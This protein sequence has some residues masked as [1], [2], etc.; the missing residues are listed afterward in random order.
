[1]APQSQVFSDDFA[2]AFQKL[3]DGNGKANEIFQQAMQ[4]LRDSGHAYD[5]KTLHPD[6][7]MTHT[8]NRGGLMLSPYNCHSNAR[9]E[10]HNVGADCKQ[11][12]NAVAVELSEQNSAGHIQANERLIKRSKG[13]L[14]PLNGKERYA[15]LGAGHT[16]AWCKLAG[17]GGPTPEKPLQDEHGKIDVQKICRNAEFKAMIEE[18]WSWEIVKAAVDVRFP[19]FAVIAQEALNTQ[20]HV[21]RRW[22]YLGLRE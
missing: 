5:M 9:K 8:R 11:L 6:L 20:N 2:T 10:V 13:L 4:M 12:S 15:T 7:F 17:V 1:M 18:G 3:L 19:R 16:A 22:Q 21:A 14:A